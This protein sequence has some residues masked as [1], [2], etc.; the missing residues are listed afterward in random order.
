MKLLALDTSTVACSAALASGDEILERHEVRPKEHTRLLLPMLRELLGEARLAP[1]DLDAV[2]LGNG[3]GSFIGLRI[4]ASVAQGICYAAGVQLVPVSSLAAVAAE[5]FQS[6][7]AGRVL[8]A[9]DAHM[10]EVYLGAYRRG[11]DGLPLAEGDA[12]LQPVTA[13]EG[14]PGIDAEECWHAAGDGWRQYPGLL[15]ANKGRLAGVIDVSWPR[16]RYLLAPG[17]RA[18]RAGGAI[19]PDALVPEYVRER[20]A[21]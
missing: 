3:P 2:V 9:Q 15:A 14:L 8:V 6:G 16:A 4:G 20:V 5:A 13:A 18:L 21:A 10:H 17:L 11:E 12:M 1:A 19:D 7:S